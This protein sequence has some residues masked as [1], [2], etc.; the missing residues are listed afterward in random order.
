MISDIGFT[1]YIG[2]TG[3]FSQED[4]RHSHYWLYTILDFIIVVDFIIII[5]II[6][7]NEGFASYYPKYP[8]IETLGSRK[9]AE[10]LFPYFRLSMFKSHTVTDGKPECVRPLFV[11]NSKSNTNA[12]DYTVPVELPSKEDRLS[13]DQGHF[14][15]DVI[16]KQ[17]FDNE[18]LIMDIFSDFVSCSVRIHLLICYDGHCTHPA[19]SHSC[20]IIHQSKFDSKEYYCEGS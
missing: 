9:T 13:K 5:R 17:N 8:C 3:K 4:I 15:V 12:C 18:V 19:I 20:L 10:G 7:L 1:V 11:T 16:P 14:E 2:R 6:T